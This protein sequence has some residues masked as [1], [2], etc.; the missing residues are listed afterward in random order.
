MARL[1]ELGAGRLR[2]EGELNLQTVP[3][4]AREARHLFPGRQSRRAKQPAAATPLELDL[5][6]VTQASSVAVALML[7]W[8]V[9]AR[10]AG[11]SLRILNWPPSMI[12]IARFSNL[13][14]LLDLPASGD[15]TLQ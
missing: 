15:Q 9:R 1:I 6:G 12:R 10:A 2:L 7:D 11:T 3:A 8:L 14:E 13:A 4:L 5:S